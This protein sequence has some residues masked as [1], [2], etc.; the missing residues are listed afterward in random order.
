M[1][2][3]FL[4]LVLVG[5]CGPAFQEDLF[6]GKQ[7]AASTVEVPQDVYVPETEASTETDAGHPEGSTTLVGDASIE[8]CSCA[9]LCSGAYSPRVC[10]S[11]YHAPCPSWEGG[12]P[13]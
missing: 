2:K 1:N 11:C 10:E 3:T 8:A 6:G 5:A 12:L 4:L 7:D 9:E 13:Q